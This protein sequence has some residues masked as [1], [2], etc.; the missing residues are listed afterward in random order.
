M[1]AAAFAFVACSNDETILQAEPEAIGFD[2]AFIE[3]STRSGYVTP[4]VDF[5]KLE[6][7]LIISLV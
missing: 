7:V 1:I 4:A 3:N 2:N 5:S 6:T